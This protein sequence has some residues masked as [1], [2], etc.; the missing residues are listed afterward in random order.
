MNMKFVDVFELLC[1]NIATNSVVS[2]CNTACSS[3]ITAEVFLCRSFQLAI[4][5][6]SQKKTRHQTLAHNFPKCQ[7]IFKIL[8]LFDSLVNL[9]L[10]HI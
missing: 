6:V 9:Q 1:V 4:N 2:K 5:T 8:S 3:F 10:T 7:P